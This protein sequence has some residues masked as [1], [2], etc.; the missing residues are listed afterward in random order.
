MGASENAREVDKFGAFKM[1][2]AEQ[3]ETH[4]NQKNK[5]KNNDYSLKKKGKK[6][7]K[8]HTFDIQV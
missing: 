3:M 4:K 6:K 7:Q 5:N 8:L 2:D 1:P